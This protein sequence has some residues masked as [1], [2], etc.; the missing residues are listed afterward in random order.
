MSLVEAAKDLIQA[1]MWFHRRVSL[2]GD[3]DA[4]DRA[5]AIKSRDNVAATMT[6]AQIAEAQRMARQWSPT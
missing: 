4:A 3:P 2:P 6:P 5:N 1:Y